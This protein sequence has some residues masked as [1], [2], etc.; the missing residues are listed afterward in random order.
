MRGGPE[1]VEPDR[2][3]V[4]ARHAVAAPTDE[5]SAEKRRELAI[6]HGVWQG[7]TVSC[8]RHH[9]ARIAAVPGVARKQRV[10]AQVL[11]ACAAIRTYAAGEAEPGNTHALADRKSCHVG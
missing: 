7:K 4:L 2:V 9:V 11:P 10:I 6:I 3:G 1:A 8:I 5:A